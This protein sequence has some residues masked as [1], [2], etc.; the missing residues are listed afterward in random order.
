PGLQ[1]ERAYWLDARWED[2]P[3]IPVDIVAGRHTNTE[4]TARTLSVSITPEETRLLLQEVPGAYHTQINDALLAAL[5]LSFA[6]WTGE[7]RLLL[8]LEGHGREELFEDVDL[9]RSVGWFTMRFPVL[10]SLRAPGGRSELP[11]PGEALL[12][13]KEQLREIPGHGIGYGVLRY[14]SEDQEAIERL[15]AFPGPQ[16]SF[17]YFGRQE[18][19]ASE[20]ACLTPE[21]APWGAARDPEGERSFV[22]EINAQVL[23]DRLTLDWT[24]SEQI[25]RHKT[26]ERVARMYIE[27]I[28]AII[29]HCQEPG[30][31]GYTPADFPL[32]E[33]DEQQLSELEQLLQKHDASGGRTAWD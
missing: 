29:A 10:L 26:I 13:V 4:G 6:R 24:Y 16:V 25:H 30:A 28:R 15:R 9:S 19:A 7:R 1:A 22:L 2:A 5:A 20:D 11:G 23:A 12:A 8:Q 3:A 14:L 31:G 21:E 32:V 17:N 33:L 27:A 18:A